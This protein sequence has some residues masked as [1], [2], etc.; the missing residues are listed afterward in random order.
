MDHG[1]ID[2]DPGR[3][4]FRKGRYE[5]RSCDQNNRKDCVND[6]RFLTRFLRFY[7]TSAAY[8]SVPPQSPHTVPLAQHLRH[9]PALRSSPERLHEPATEIG[10]LIFQTMP[11]P[12]LTMQD[13][14]LR[15][16]TRVSRLAQGSA[17]CVTDWRM[18]GP[19]PPDPAAV[20][21]VFFFFILAPSVVLCSWSIRY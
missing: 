9:F 12:C 15:R 17:S 3:I 6:G 21:R 14:A 10:T 18:Q 8:P 20:G 13:N 2:R 1:R 16:I 19:I 5:R 4:H 11:E 7:R